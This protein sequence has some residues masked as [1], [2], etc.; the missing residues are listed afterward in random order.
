M[1]H[2]LERDIKSFKSFYWFPT[3]PFRDNEIVTAL[4]VLNRSLPKQSH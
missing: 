1:L 4:P 3:K 2:L